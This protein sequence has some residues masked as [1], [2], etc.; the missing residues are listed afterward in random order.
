MSYLNK[1]GKKLKIKQK[2]LNLGKNSVLK[3]MDKAE[4]M[5]SLSPFGSLE[6]VILQRSTCIHK[7]FFFFFFNK[8]QQ[9]G[10][11]RSPNS[12]DNNACNGVPGVVSRNESD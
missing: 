1:T 11:M 3:G 4:M 6:L 8:R 7:L 5:S 12:S 9:C 2:P 10:D